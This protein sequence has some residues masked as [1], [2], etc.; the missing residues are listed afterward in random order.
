MVDSV[1]VAAMPGK[2]APDARCS[3]MVH[4]PLEPWGPSLNTF[5][6]FTLVFYHWYLFKLQNM[7]EARS[8]ATKN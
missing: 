2:R 7:R 8:I 1:S 6:T 3:D 5:F 4:K